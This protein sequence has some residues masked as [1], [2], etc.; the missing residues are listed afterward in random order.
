MPCVFVYFDEMDFPEDG[1]D[2]YENF[3]HA[4]LRIDYYAVGLVETGLNE[5]NEIE[6]LK[7]AEENAE[8]RL[9]YLT[10]QLYKI[11]CCEQNL[12][13][14]TNNLVT[15]TRIKKWKRMPTPK[16]Y[17][18]SGAVLAASFFLELGFLEPT[19]YCDTKEIMEFY[20]TLE[21]QDEYIDPFIKIILNS[22]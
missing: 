8:D 21:I 22:D 5:E 9:N 18:S 1:Q 10:A 11:L 2:I 15:R 20:T 12:K 4:N 7:K 14:G 19:Y 17:E 16:G 6:I 3:V 13:K